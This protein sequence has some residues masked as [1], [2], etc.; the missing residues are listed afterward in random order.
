MGGDGCLVSL[1]V[2]AGKGAAERWRRRKESGAGG[3][4]CLVSLLDG[5]GED[6]VDTPEAMFAQLKVLSL[7]TF[8]AGVEG[9][10]ILRDASLCAFT[11]VAYS[12]GAS[13]TSSQ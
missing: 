6:E 12:A 4:G 2:G 5:A 10:P 3:G 9:K 11:G 13:G 1:L 7:S 8:R